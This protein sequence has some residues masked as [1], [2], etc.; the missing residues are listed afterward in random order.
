MRARLTT[1]D[2]SGIILFVGAALLCV[3]FG[4]P[5]SIASFAPPT[6]GSRRIAYVQGGCV[7]TCN[8]PRP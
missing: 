6:S 2:F 1:L 3:L 7:H 5:D 8:I 4:D